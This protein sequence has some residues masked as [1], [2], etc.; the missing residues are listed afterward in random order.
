MPLKAE[1]NEVLIKTLKQ[2]GKKQTKPKKQK[3]TEGYS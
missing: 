2:K 3:Q 1:D